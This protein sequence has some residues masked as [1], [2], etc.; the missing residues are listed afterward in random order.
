LAYDAASAMMNSLTDRREQTIDRLQKRKRITDGEVDNLRALLVPVDGLAAMA[1]TD[2]V[3]EAVSENAKTKL[4]VYQALRDAG[5]TGL[6]T[7]NT[8]SVTRASLLSDGTIDSKHFALTHFFS[9]V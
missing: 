3:T 9:P 4:A 8:S 5:F 6:L 2:L 1:Q 7:T